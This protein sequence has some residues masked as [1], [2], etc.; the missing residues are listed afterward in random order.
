MYRF[1]MVTVAAN[2]LISAITDRM[3]AIVQAESWGEWLGG[4]QASPEELKALLKP[5]EGEWTMS[6][7]AK[8]TK[9]SKAPPADSSSILF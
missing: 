4:E 5:F 1:V 2:K 7:E 9:P 6:L 3:P 8:K